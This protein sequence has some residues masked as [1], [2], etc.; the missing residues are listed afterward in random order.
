MPHDAKSQ[1]EHVARKANHIPK[2]SGGSSSARHP[3]ME[4]Q[5]SAGNHTVQQLIRSSFIQTKL[6]VSTPEDPA[7]READRVAENVVARKSKSHIPVAVREDGD[8]EETPVNRLCNECEDEMVHRAEGHHASGTQHQIRNSTAQSIRGLNGHGSPLPEA[9]RSFF[10]P[11]F[12]ADFSHVRVHTDSHAA[13]TARSIN[14]KAFTV[15]PNIAFA[16][17]HYAPH[18]AEG[19]KILAHELTH[20]VQQSAGS[21][22]VSRDAEPA[23]SKT[24][25]E[26]QSSAPKAEDLIAARY[27]HV[28]NVLNRK[29]LEV[30]QKFINFRVK[31]RIVSGKVSAFEKRERERA[32][33]EDRLGTYTLMSDYERRRSRVESEYPDYPKEDTVEIDTARL[34]DASVLDEQPW[35]VEA[36]RKFRE[37]WVLEL[38]SKPTTLDLGGEQP[39]EEVF[40][41]FFWGEKGS[42]VYLPTERGLITFKKLLEIPQAKR[43]YNK[44]VVNGEFVQAVKTAHI[45]VEYLFNQAKG[46]YDAEVERR[47]EFPVV[48]TIAEFFGSSIDFAVAAQFLPKGKSFADMAPFEIMEFLSS[49]KQDQLDQVIRELPSRDAWNKVARHYLSVSKAVQEGKYEAAI[50]VMPIIADE[51]EKILRKT[52]AYRARTL[53]GAGT[54]VTALQAVRVG[55]NIALTIM[56]GVAGKAY[57]LLGVSAGSAA[58]AGGATLTQETAMQLSE[59]RFDPGSILAKAGKDAA[60]TFIG[61]YIGGSLAGKFQGI[62]NARLA[63][64]IPNE[65]LRLFMA[66]RVADLASGVLTTPIEMVVDGMLEGNWPESMDDFLS[67]VA[68]NTIKQV[69][70]GGG[71]DIGIHGFKKLT[72]GGAPETPVGAPEKISGEP[73]TSG[74]VPTQAEIEPTAAKEV[75]FQGPAKEAGHDIRI[76]RGGEVKYCSEPCV[77]ISLVYGQVL[78]QNPDLKGQF[79]SI[80][81]TAQTAERMIASSDPEVVKVGEKLLKTAYGDAQ[82]L[83]NKLATTG[84]RVGGTRFRPEPDLL[85]EGR[86]GVAWKDSDAIAR[87][88]RTGKPEGRFGGLEDIQ[89]AVELAAKLGPGR[90]MQPPFPNLPADTRSVVFMPDGSKVPATTIFVKVRSNG[91]FHAYPLP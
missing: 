48:S 58:G 32:I 6:R 14:A 84:I 2:R 45:D 61:S 41:G 70:I 43:E 55:C 62:F 12:G 87:A 75:L 23:T 77:N 25:K 9:T 19:Q 10:E 59:G 26:K 67:K 91:S 38:S 53:E 20:V 34:I 76:E 52:Y 39:I 68:D 80:R 90:T 71:I 85:G 13:E 27:P 21:R 66:N 1:V 51:I 8:E 16:S 33:R 64:Q 28:L 79:K 65:T 50:V 30:I 3:L 24:S 11:R 57:G 82:R 72:V 54:V 81:S 63:A 35:N 18:S 40:R 74:K 31:N 46:A 56:G 37:R 5:Q 69:I 29:Q 88:R 49:L 60:I 36:E 42:Q 22:K 17:G 83:Q 7:E 15:G 47:A 4:L 86:H 44:D 89:Y 78:E 73:V